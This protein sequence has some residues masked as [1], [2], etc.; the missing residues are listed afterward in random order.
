[1][2]RRNREDEIVGLRLRGGTDTGHGK[3]DVNGGTHTTEEELSLQEDLAV[4]DGDDLQNK[5]TIY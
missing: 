2:N 3:T 5:N 4:G 1:M